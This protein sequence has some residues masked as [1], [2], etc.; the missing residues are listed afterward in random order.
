MAGVDRVLQVTPSI[1]GWDNEYA[2]ES[3]ARFPDRIVAVIGR[4][5]P[6]GAGL[7]KRLAE[8]KARKVVGVRVTLI[9][10]M[11]EW[12]RDGTME[13]LLDEAGKIGMLV[14]IF[15]PGQPLEMLAAAKRHP[16]TQIFID[17]MSVSYV[18]D[19][20]YAQW[21]DAL[22]L[23]EA[24][25]VW[26]KASAFPDSAHTR[27]PWTNVAGYFKELYERFG[28]DRLIWGSNYPPCTSAGTYKESVDF[29]TSLPF[30]DDEAKAK[31]F[32]KTL[33]RAIGLER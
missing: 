28:P 23:A 22:R 17:H 26:M 25:N 29:A 31:I 10:A 20:P 24:P 9:N 5:D 21:A 27:Y 14:Q 6:R 13:A 8:L 2:I 30:L 11:T 3:A 4:I 33:L 19:K 15:G 16:G 1:M 7:A 12:L 18:D 32:G